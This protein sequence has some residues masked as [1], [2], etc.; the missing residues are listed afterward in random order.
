M[1][2]KGGR[3]GCGVIGDEH[4]S[5]VQCIEALRRRLAAAEVR[6]ESFRTPGRLAEK[7]R[8]YGSIAE[9]GHCFESLK[10][11]LLVLDARLAAVEGRLLEIRAV[12]S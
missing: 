10:E 11:H 1:A 7:M 3:R 4:R 2:S 6:L 8:E 5:R 12:G 9:L